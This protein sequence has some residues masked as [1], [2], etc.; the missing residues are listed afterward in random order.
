MYRGSDN[1]IHE[2]FLFNGGSA[3]GTGDLTAAAGATPT[4]G[5]PAAYVRS[6]GVNAVVYRGSDNHIHELFLLNGGS[7]WGTGDLTAATGATP[8]RELTLE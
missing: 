4:A 7:A 8:A 1:H 2:L 6:D 3:W 5:D